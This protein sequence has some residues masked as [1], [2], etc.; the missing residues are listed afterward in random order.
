MGGGKVSSS[1]IS[2]HRLRRLTTQAG[3]LSKSNSGRLAGIGDLVTHG[4]TAAHH[5]RKEGG[6]S[7]SEAFIVGSS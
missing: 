1:W 3:F 6:E 2:D 4:T 5:V 7:C